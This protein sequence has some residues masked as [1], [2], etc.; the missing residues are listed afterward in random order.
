MLKSPAEFEDV[1]TGYIPYIAAE[2]IGCSLVPRPLTPELPIVSC[3]E[4]QTNPTPPVT[5]TSSTRITPPASPPAGPT[6]RPKRS[7][8]P[9]ISGRRIAVL[10]TM[11]RPRPLRTQQSANTVLRGT[12][13]ARWSPPTVRRPP[14]AALGAPPPDGDGGSS[15]EEEGELPELPEDGIRLLLVTSRSLV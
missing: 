14:S 7:P 15:S 4:T 9:R 8:P 3:S 12:T 6:T 13:P 5:V 10:S 2:R 1:L 11:P